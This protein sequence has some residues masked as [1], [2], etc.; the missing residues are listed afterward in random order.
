MLSVSNISQ[1]EARTFTVATVGGAIAIWD[2]AFNLGVYDTIFFEKIFFVWAA[3]VAVF[4]VSVVLPDEYA[5]VNWWQRIVL[6]LPTVWIILALIVDPAIDASTIDGWMLLIGAV[7]YALCLPFTLYIITA[8][9]NPEFFAFKTKALGVAL[10]IIVLIVAVTSY[11][12]GANN[13]LFL[14]CEDFKVS[15]N[16]IPPNCTEDFS[17]DLSD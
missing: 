15:G 6:I 11:F 10:A 1:S 12:V 8:I 7:I 16:D 2:I 13:S 4:G 17:F 3:S 14:T 9:T 5:P